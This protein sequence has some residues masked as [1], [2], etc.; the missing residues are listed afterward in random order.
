MQGVAMRASSKDFRVYLDCLSMRD[1]DAIVENANDSEI[2]FG[3]PSVPI[4][5]TV[6]YAASFIDIA[7]QKLADGDEYHLGIRLLDG[8]LIGLC[9]LAH[10]DKAN[11]KAEL[12][13]WIGK[14]YRGKG[15]AK[16]ALELALGLGFAKLGLNRVYARV[17]ADNERSK[18]LLESLGFVEE[19]TNRMDVM[20]NGR[21]IDSKTLG[22][23]KSEYKSTVEVEFG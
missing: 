16:E 14:T 11:R 15:Y 3:D 9:A 20:R 22:L 1:V 6:E 2:A 12:G 21:F 18:R 4:P 10:I 17:L 13:Y 23:L 19:G 8:T 5:Y 7:M